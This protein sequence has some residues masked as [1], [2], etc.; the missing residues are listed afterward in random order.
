MI[1]ESKL[2]SID[3]D[4]PELQEDSP[5]ISMKMAKRL[6]DEEIDKS[7]QELGLQK[8]SRSTLSSLRKIG[9]GAEQEGAIHISAGVVLFGVE[10]GIKIL[11]KVSNLV[12]GAIKYEQD[13][14]SDG[15]PVG[16]GEVAV[17]LEGAKAADGLIKTLNDSAKTIKSLREQQ[18]LKDPEK[19]SGK[20]NGASMAKPGVAVQIVVDKDRNVKIGGDQ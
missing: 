19:E 8:I 9:L 20:K 10:H 14:D 6:S 15:N 11:E 18:F 3:I 1:T 13:Q 17:V 7:A 4:S 16:P 12:T 2:P 5:D